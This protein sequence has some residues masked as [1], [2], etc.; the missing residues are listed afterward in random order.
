MSADEKPLVSV[1]CANYNHSQ[2]L[3]QSVKSLLEQTYEN[4]EIILV[5]DGSTDDSLERMHQLKTLDSRIKVLSYGENKGKWFALNYAIG[6]SNG[7]LISLLDAD[8]QSLP[9]RFE[10]QVKCLQEQKSLHNLSG[11]YHCYSQEEMNS[12]KLDHVSKFGSDP[13]E[14]LGHKHVLQYAHA[15]YKHPN[16]NHFIVDSHYEVH[17]AS[18]LFYRQIWENG[19]KFA[20][21]K[22]GLRICKSEDS[23]H[24]LKFVLMLQK[25]S[26]IKEP[27]ILYRRNTGTNPAP[28][29]EL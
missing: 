3:E 17:G 29:E 20:P 12:K 7:R 25:T 26:V 16:V 23:D 9:E 19:L 22:I 14:I 6:R 24:N 28:W 10:R 8:D 15:G 18:S 5:D 27:L 1:V 11:F 13:M 2:Y 4:L 21:G